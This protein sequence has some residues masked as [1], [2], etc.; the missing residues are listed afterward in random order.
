MVDKVS[1]TSRY[2]RLAYYSKESPPH[3]SACCCLRL[4]V[5]RLSPPCP[6]RGILIWEFANKRTVGDRYPFVDAL[7]M[8]PDCYNLYLYKQRYS[9]KLLHQ[10]SRMAKYCATFWKG[11]T[12]QK[13]F[14]KKVNQ[15]SRYLNDNRLDDVSWL[16]KQFETRASAGLSKWYEDISKSFGCVREE[17]IFFYRLLDGK[18][19]SGGNR[20]APTPPSDLVIYVFIIITIPPIPCR[21][22]SG[23]LGVRRTNP[24]GVRP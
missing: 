18:E 11:P 8:I 9:Q 15:M 4:D 23:L 2:M 5:A 21:R 16:G 22:S 1:A 7:S 6:F 17:D 12:L 19:M 13:L 14:Q 24:G 20:S 3:Q 10:S